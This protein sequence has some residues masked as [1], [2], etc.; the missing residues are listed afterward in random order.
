MAGK[1]IAAG[2]KVRVFD[3]VPD[4]RQPLCDLGAHDASSAA[5]AVTGAAAVILML[6]DSDIVESLLLAPEIGAA[7]ASGPIVIDMSSSEPLRTRALGEELGRRGIVIVDAPVSGG[8]RRA[9]TGTLT[10][11][12]GGDESTIVKVDPLLSAMGT[13]VRTGPLGSGHAMKA[14]N[15]LLSATHLLATAEAMVAG[16]RFGLDPRVMLDVL[17]ASSGRSGS[18]ENKWPNFVVTGRFDS[19]FA[20]RLMVKDMRIATTLARNVK[21]PS[22]LGECAASLW[23]AAAEAL[24]FDA[25]H[26]E[27]ARWVKVS[28]PEGNA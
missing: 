1:V 7:L 24:P 16:E 12:A 2:Y 17:N 20:L 8:V 13:V 22:A 9:S 23:G 14:L 4:R 27:I 19:G 18:T 6:P 11:M 10:I 5:V 15:N 28:E 25:D 21:G 26:T 3:T